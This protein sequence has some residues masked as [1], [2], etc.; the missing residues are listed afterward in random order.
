MRY[1]ALIPLLPGL[2]A[3]VIGVV[4]IRFF[5]RRTSALFACGTMAA[6]LALSVWAFVELLARPADAREQVVTLA[7]W[8]P[9]MALQTARGIGTYA[10]DWSLR[11]DPLSAVMIL[12]VTGIGFLI[13]VYSTAYM[14][15]ES[16]G[17]YA[18]YFSYL[19][20]FCFF[21]LTLV[22][23]AN[24]L[25]MFVGWEGVG[26]CSYLLIGYW[27]EKKSASDAGKKAFLVNRIGDFGFILG[28]LLVFFTFGTLD[29]RAVADAAAALPVETAAFGTLS[30]VCILLFVGATGKSAQIPLY[31]WLPDAME[32]PTPVSALI[33]AATMVTAGVYM[34]CR[35]AVL[36]TH[37]PIVMEVVAVI[38]VLTA[39]VAASIGLV[40]NDIKRVLAYSTVSQLGYMFLATGVGAF[41][42]GAFHL[43]T[44]GFF[45]A[46]LFLGSG[47]VIHGMGGEQD[48]RRM[49]AL[50]QYLP[51]TFA[52]MMVGTLAI[53]GVPPLSGFFSKDEILYR[54]FL[55]N[56]LFWG[57]AVVTAAMTAF[58]MFRL[59]ALTFYGA[60][61]GPAWASAHDAHPPASGHQAPSAPGHGGGHGAWRGPHEAPR[62]MTIPL[63][64]LAAGA[65]VA[66]VVGVPAALGGGN[67]IERFLEP[68]FTARASGVGHG[69]AATGPGATVHGPSPGAPVTTS[70]MPGTGSERA[71][72]AD[73]PGGGGHD[74]AEH[75]SAA[76]ELSL[77]AF[78]VVVALVGIG[79][80]WH[81]YVRRSELADALQARY[82]AAHRVLTNKYYVDEL[83]HATAVRGTL[84]SARYLWWF[85]LRVIDGLVNG[86]AWFT[87]FSAWLSG[88]VDRTVVDGL[89]NGTGS[90]LREA[91]HGFRR[92]QTG[93]VQNYALLMMIGV[94]G[95][96][97]VY[98]LV[99]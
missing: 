70:S 16:A 45:K 29:F 61:R 85:D 12:V 94:F 57:L 13:H 91:S 74:Q 82:A 60:Y 15:D 7:T 88:L 36:F 84:L 42:A 56:R 48:M 72:T 39:F 93:L 54:T 55:G 28:M 10:V 43:M 3:L 1:L 46:L 38:G 51:V 99:R 11:L 23:G 9:P 40:Q 66:G 24:F 58:Y 80:A 49:G 59:M 68:S 17:A 87:R 62:A 31:V 21:M 18:R 4:G 81:I 35:N 5:A 41:A 50:R 92:L 64:I 86:S 26:L 22:L 78:S 95:L 79:A 53:A 83:Y 98:L 8:I 89:V 67:V 76:G 73:G 19:N 27:Y 90:S 96:V 47:S 2:G 77:M 37:A 52:T 44:H 32:G 69:E 75:L 14:H 30:L 65:V 34:V 20:L 33:H 63:L 25:V 71:V 97:S 6:S